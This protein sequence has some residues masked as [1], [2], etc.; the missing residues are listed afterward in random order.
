MTKRRVAPRTG[1]NKGSNISKITQMEDR[2]Q[3]RGTKLALHW[4]GGMGNGVPGKTD[5]FVSGLASKKP[6]NVTAGNLKS[7]QIKRVSGG[8]TVT[9]NY[10][11]LG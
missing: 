10:S 8:P 9:T 5:E 1:K 2:N 11:F 3:G 4:R 7:L 6:K